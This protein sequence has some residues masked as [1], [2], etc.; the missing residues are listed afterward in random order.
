M[1]LHS[2]NLLNVNLKNSVNRRGASLIGMGSLILALAVAP[3]ADASNLYLF[4]SRADINFSHESGGTYFYDFC[5][6]SFDKPFHEFYMV[7]D[8]S[9]VVLDCP[10]DPV[11]GDIEFVSAE[12]LSDD[13]DLWFSDDMRSF[14]NMDEPRLLNDNMM[15]AYDPDKSDP[16]APNTMVIKAQFGFNKSL[17]D[18][19]YQ[20]G[21]WAGDLRGMIDD[22]F[23]FTE[24][25][26]Q[27]IPEPT[28]LLLTLL[29]GAGLYRFRR[30]A[31]DNN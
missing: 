4:D 27:P 24:S 6:T 26:G 14:A 10:T 19:M 2:V 7:L 23:E 13:V 12:I 25:D 18:E 22:N 16:F 3:S 11:S 20:M 15:D 21:Y 5:L 9:K 29:G 31:Q 1:F 28:T 8:P 30:K 17:G